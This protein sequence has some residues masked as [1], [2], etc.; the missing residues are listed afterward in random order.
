MKRQAY[1]AVT[2][3]AGF[4]DWLATELESDVLFHHQYVDRR[5]SEIWQCEGLFDAFEGYRWNHPGNQRLGYPA[6]NTPLSNAVALAALQQ[7]LRVSLDH[8]G[9]SLQATLEVMAWGGVTARNGDWLKANQQG[10]AATLRSVK[11]AL[12]AG[13]DDASVL[14]A[15]SLRFNSGMTKVYSLICDDFLIYDSRVAAALGWLVVK[16]CKGKQ[17][18]RVPAE[19]CFPWAAAKEGQNSEVPKVRNPG[20][21][22]LHFKRL[23]AGHHHALWNLRASWLLSA[24]LAHPAA[25]SSRFN[26]VEGPVTPLRA[27][28][29]ACFMIG[30]DLGG[31]ECSE[32]FAQRIL[33]VRDEDFVEVDADVLIAQL[34]E[35]LEAARNKENGRV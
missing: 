22:G 21:G 12:D 24:V 8:D 33:A 20:E 27:L 4:I 3:V 32:A 34:D 30:Y 13:D 35:M 26:Q 10:L 19:L 28:E 31:E 2:H 29:A 18:E 14:R 6:G 11:A 9:R 1:L 7:D 23:R 15:K 16:Y 25:S 17:L 5:R